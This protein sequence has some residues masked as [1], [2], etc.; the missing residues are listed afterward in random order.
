MSYNSDNK[1]YIMRCFPKKGK[2][3]AEV[4]SKYCKD[5]YEKYQKFSTFHVW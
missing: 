5:D 4:I 3:P 2:L 1:S